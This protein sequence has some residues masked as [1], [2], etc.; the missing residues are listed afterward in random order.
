ML[1][2]K[3]SQEIPLNPIFLYFNS[4]NFE[5]FFFSYPLVSTVLAIY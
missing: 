2:D 4:H 5:C 1:N 3:M